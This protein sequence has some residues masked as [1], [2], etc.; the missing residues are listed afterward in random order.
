MLIALIVTS[1][2]I[3]RSIVT[4]DHNSNDE[5]IHVANLANI[6]QQCYVLS[7]SRAR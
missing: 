2:M 7:S 1:M 6:N 4:I 5:H 3:R